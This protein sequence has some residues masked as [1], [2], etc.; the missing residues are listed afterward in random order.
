MTT[1]GNT[2]A[3]QLTDI[4]S[5][6]GMTLATKMALKYANIL[7]KQKPSITPEQTMRAFAELLAAT[8]AGKDPIQ[9]AEDIVA[10]SMGE[11]AVAADET[12]ASQ[13]AAPTEATTVATPAADPAPATDSSDASTAT[14]AAAEI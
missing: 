13:G 4:A 10:V 8:V 14:S 6:F 2:F 12:L 5:K 9:I 3:S 7:A 1:D 11:P